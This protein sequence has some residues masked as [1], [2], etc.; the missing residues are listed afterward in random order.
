MEKV[1]GIRGEVGNL[2]AVAAKTSRWNAETLEAIDG[3]YSL[4]IAVVQDTSG[5]TSAKLST[6]QRVKPRR[7]AAGEECD[8]LL[9]A[10][11]S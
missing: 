5:G 3:R 9:E 7:L 4:L 1:E 2:S 10:V 6:I 11:N 8:A